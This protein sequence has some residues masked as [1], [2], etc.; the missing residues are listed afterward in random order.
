[1]VEDSFLPANAEVDLNQPRPGFREHLRDN[2]LNRQAILPAQPLLRLGEQ[3]E[4]PRAAWGLHRELL[5]VWSVRDSVAV[6]ILVVG[7]QAIHEQHVV[8]RA[9]AFDVMDGPVPRI[10][11]AI[12]HQRNAL[13]V[14]ERT[15]DLHGGRVLVL[16]IR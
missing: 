16:P 3:H 14:R 5:L 15:D 9:V 12:A 11:L 10:Q 8:M 4:Q 13:P 2:K 6:A 7:R 1:M